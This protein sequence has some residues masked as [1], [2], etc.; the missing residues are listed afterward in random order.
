M[1]ENKNEESENSIIMKFKVSEIFSIFLEQVD[2]RGL[3][4]R[5][6]SISGAGDF[7]AV[8]LARVMRE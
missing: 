1:K 7:L 2:V 4:L 8:L 6:K 5:K 3:Y